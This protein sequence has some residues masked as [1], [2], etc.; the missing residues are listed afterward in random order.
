MGEGLRSAGLK[1]TALVLYILYV[2]ITLVK[3]CNVSVFRFYIFSNK[4]DLLE[5]TCF[6]I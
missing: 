6:I 3:S 1:G 4:L 5:V 2:L